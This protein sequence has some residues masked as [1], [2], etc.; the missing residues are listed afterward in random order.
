MKKE[1]LALGDRKNK[2]VFGN[3]E[4]EEKLSQYQVGESRFCED[5]QE[6]KETKI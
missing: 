3:G 5:K 6:K 4:K 1:K 2:F